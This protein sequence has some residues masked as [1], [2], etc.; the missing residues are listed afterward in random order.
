MRGGDL[1]GGLEGS[2]RRVIVGN[3]MGVLVCW[4]DVCVGVMGVLV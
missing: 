4:C 1:R 2:R 3:V